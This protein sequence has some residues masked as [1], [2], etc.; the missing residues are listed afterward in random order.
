MCACACV[1]YIYTQTRAIRVKIQLCNFLFFFIRSLF[2]CLFFF[3]CSPF[4]LFV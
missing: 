4:H 2:V 1:V 3:V